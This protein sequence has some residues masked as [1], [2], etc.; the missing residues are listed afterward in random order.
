MYIYTPKNENPEFEDCS[1]LKWW[2]ISVRS[3][4][5]AIIFQKKQISVNTNGA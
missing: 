5:L 3:F 2:I 4:A 1:S